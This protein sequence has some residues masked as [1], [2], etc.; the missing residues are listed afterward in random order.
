[1]HRAATCRGSAGGTFKLHH[2]TFWITDVD[3]GSIAIGAIA[4]LG[5][6]R[7]DAVL[8]EVCNNRK[9]IER[10]DPQAQVVHVPSFRARCSTAFLAEFSV[11]GNQIDH[12]LSRAQL[13]QSD[14]LPRPLDAAAQYV[15]VKLCHTRRILHA[16][17]DVIETE[18]VDHEQ[19]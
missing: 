13:Y 10:F 16:Q 1:V 19:P 8:D 5:F 14:V 2:I 15:T 6:A 9:L 12:G 7:N 3:G 17:H 11:Y 4:V 18:D